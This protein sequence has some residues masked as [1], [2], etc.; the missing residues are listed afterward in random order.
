MKNQT[1]QTEKIKSWGAGYFGIDAEGEVVC[2]PTSDTSRPVS[3]Q[4]I[5]QRTVAAGYQPPFSIRF[6]QII[7]SQLNRI[8]TAF[9]DA[10]REFNYPRRHYGVFPLKVNQS[11]SFVR[12]LLQYG[13]AYDYGLEVGSKSELVAAMGLPMSAD[14][15]LVC[16]GFKD[17]EFFELTC[18]A[19]AKHRHVL[20][21]IES[22]AELQPLLKV[23]LAHKNI[24]RIGFRIRLSHCCSSR[25]ND[26][27][28][29]TSKF[30]LNTFELLELLKELQRH[31]CTAQVQ[32][33]HFHAGS[34]ITE[35]STFKRSLKEAARIYSKV[36]KM[37]FPLQYLNIGGGLGVDY[38]GNKAAPPFNTNYEPQEFINDAVY[39]IAAT[40]REEGIPVPF[41]VSESGRVIAAY[42]ALV[43][44]DVRKTHAT[45][46]TDS[47]LVVAKKSKPLQELTF[48]AANL[49]S[50][51]FLEYYHDAI[52]HYSDLLK[53]F[54][55]G[56]IDLVERAK[57]EEL[58]MKICLH[59]HG[60]MQKDPRLTDEFSK[61]QKN[62]MGKYL[63]NFSIFQSLPDAWAIG[64]LFPVLPL[65]RH[66]QADK[67]HIVDIT[68]DAD[69]CLSRF[70]DNDFLELP[71]LE[72]NNTCYLGFFLVGAYQSSLG[73]THNLFGTTHA[74]EV[75][76]DSDNC[77]TMIDVG[78]S[79][80][81]L[82]RSSGYN[83]EELIAEFSKNTPANQNQQLL[84]KYKAFLNSYPYL[85]LS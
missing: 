12:A 18:L 71:A 50:E 29:F 15:L 3:L 47:P 55:L 9:G 81:D 74:V 14:S 2:Y 43:V 85:N 31:D 23:L 61:L 67:A 64:Q 62:L 7:A 63:A 5:V 38:E 37:G 56:F 24:P 39:V 26:N 1:E 20:V 42:Y 11:R 33:L 82:L 58:Y 69:G 34:Q 53:L 57:G 45:T 32:M 51:T 79:V 80:G 19:A 28:G 30:G 46:T 68:C 54:N 75:M 35:I 78:D 49:N 40:C 72:G 48:L 10:M 65:A 59:V 52:E 4:D 84:D 21:V 73:N 17:Q 22:L 6:P 36:V 70:I 16:N 60:F 25:W 13:R 44:T 66:Q 77:A 8:E 41:I 27:V 76:I 83:H